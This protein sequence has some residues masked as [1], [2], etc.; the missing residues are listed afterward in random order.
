MS[1]LMVQMVKNVSAMQESGVQSLVWEDPLEKGIAA[2]SSILARRIN[3]NRGAWRATIHGGH[4]ESD[5][6]EDYHFD[7]HTYTQSSTYR[8]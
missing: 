6:T 7:F 1:S 5:A 4:R 8:F 3:M 2:P